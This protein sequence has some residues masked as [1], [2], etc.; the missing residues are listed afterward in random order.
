LDRAAEQLWLRGQDEALKALANQLA[1]IIKSDDPK[2]ALLNFMHEVKVYESKNEDH[3]AVK[4]LL[5]SIRA[6]MTYGTLAALK[7]CVEDIEQGQKFAVDTAT[8][9]DTVADNPSKALEMYRERMAFYFTP[10]EWVLLENSIKQKSI[11]FAYAG[12]EEI[13]RR[14]MAEMEKAMAGMSKRDFVKNIMT[15]LETSGIK[16]APPQLTSSYLRT[17]Y[18]TVMPRAYSD[19]QDALVTTPG[20]AEVTWGYQ[21][22]VTPGYEEL[23]VN[24]KWHTKAAMHGFAAPLDHEAWSVFGWYQGGAYNCKCYRQLRSWDTAIERGWATMQLI[25]K[26]ANGNDVFKP[27]T[28]K[29]E[30]VKE[31]S[32]EWWNQFAAMEKGLE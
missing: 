23:G 29:R 6:A 22:W 14:L 31:F 13:A 27:V 20:G 17:I 18:D 15:W 3:P 24:H 8:D 11:G 5:K 21:W 7:D 1:R 26:D 25:G 16:G 30:P 19:A 2:M 4:P 12:T 32:S 28:L 10:E 9:I